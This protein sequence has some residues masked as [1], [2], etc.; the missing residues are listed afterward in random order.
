MTLPKSSPLSQLTPADRDQLLEWCSH[1]S[2]TEA[3]QLAALPRDQGG[4]ALSTSRSAL[5]RF[6]QARDRSTHGRHVLAHIAKSLDL[7]QNEDHEQFTGAIISLLETLSFEALRASDA[8]PGPVLPSLRLMLQLKKYRDEKIRQVVPQT[9]AEY[10]ASL[11]HD[12][13]ET[14][15]PSTSSRFAPSPAGQTLLER[16]AHV[17]ARQVA[18]TTQARPMPAPAAPTAPAAPAP[19]SAQP[20]APPPPAAATPT[21]ALVPAE[22]PTPSHP[23]PSPNPRH[24]ANPTSNILPYPTTPAAPEST[25]EPAPDSTANQAA[26]QPNNRKDFVRKPAPKYPQPQNRPF[27]LGALKRR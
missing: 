20:S 23:E 11:D 2:Y 18:Q 12:D 26:S 5:G 4:L 3:V 17:L 9:R 19:V 15:N 16:A 8:Q 21:P 6:H 7:S 24:P 22:P 13:D 25:P 1:L 10:L 14:A 27:Y